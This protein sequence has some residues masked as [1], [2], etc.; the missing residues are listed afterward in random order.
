M[1]ALCEMLLVRKRI[2]ALTD[3]EPVV[4]ERIE[5]FPEVVGVNDGPTVVGGWE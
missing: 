3:A 5:S 2:M 1:I 4:G